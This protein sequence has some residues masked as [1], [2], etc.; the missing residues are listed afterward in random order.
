MARFRR[1]A[2]K[3]EGLK[4]FALLVVVLTIAGFEFSHLWTSQKP[5]E[6]TPATEPNDV[7]KT[8][9]SFCGVSSKSITLPKDSYS[10]AHR[11]AAIALEGA[12]YV[13]NKAQLEEL[14]KNRKL[15]KV[16]EGLGF[17]ISTEKLTHSYPVL[18]SEALTALE[19]LG[20]AFAERL[21]GTS[22]EG[23]VF[24]VSSFTRTH[25]QQKDLRRINKAA[26]SKKSTHSYGASFDIWGVH[27]PKGD[28]HE[29]LP[30]LEAVLKEFREQQEILLCPE[31][32]CIHVTAL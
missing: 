17:V 26:T 16:N 9:V 11:P 4:R 8:E 32:K 21:K 14:V 10:K 25:Q 20:A 1:R 7:P 3:R 29:A 23:S 31:Y 5:K 27:S 2:K 28:C 6:D 15:Y 18:H 22:V 24:A 12:T 19:E 30:V 13:K